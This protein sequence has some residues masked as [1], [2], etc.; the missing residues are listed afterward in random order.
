MLN[1]SKGNMYPFVSHTW[2]TVKGKCPHNCSY[3]YMKRFGKQS[4]LHFDEKEL[5][6]DLGEGNFIFV[7]SSC[8]MWADAIPGLWIK[9]TLEH[10]RQFQNK[11]LFCFKIIIRF[12]PNQINTIC[13]FMVLITISFPIYNVN[14]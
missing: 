14:T 7:G 11:Y 1:P 9:A 13:N 3:C 12:H 2:N 10:C 6:T 5:K 4:D 8:D